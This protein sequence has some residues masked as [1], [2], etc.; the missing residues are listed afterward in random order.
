MPPRG[1]PQRPLLREMEL[2]LNPVLGEG[3]GL[4]KAI[5]RLNGLPQGPV[6]P[7]RADG[8]RQQPEVLPPGGVQRLH[9]LPDGILTEQGGL[10][11]F[12]NTAVGGQPQEMRMLPDQAV[13]KAVHRGD[14]SLG[15]QQQ[16]TPQPPVF[17]IGGQLIRQLAVQPLLHLV[18]CRLRKGGDNQPVHLH[19]VLGVG[20]PAQDALHQHRRFA[21]AGRGGYEQSPPAGFQTKLLFFCPAAIAHAVQASLR[22]C[23]ILNNNTRK[24]SVLQELPENFPISS[25]ETARGLVF[26]A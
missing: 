3:V 14:G 21:G 24:S 16:L 2:C 1:L 25:A 5:Q 10:R 8:V 9:G 19:R 15:K 7:F 6:I 18:G 20:D 22:R 17:R 11:V 4:Q 12:Q 13:T 26:C 23:S